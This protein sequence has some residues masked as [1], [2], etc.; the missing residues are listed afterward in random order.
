M[1]GGYFQG[2]RS[3]KFALFATERGLSLSAAVGTDVPT[4]ADEYSRFWHREM[5]IRNTRGHGDDIPSQVS[6]PTK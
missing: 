3:P 4:K 5:L 6:E 1:D 2:R